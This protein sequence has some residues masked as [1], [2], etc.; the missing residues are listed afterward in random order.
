[1]RLHILSDLHLEFAQFDLPKTDA[2]VVVLAGDVHVGRKGRLWIRNRFDKPVIYVTGNHEYYRHSIPELTDTLRR[3]TE[4]GHIHLLENSAVEI[5]GFSF[6]GCTL[7]SDF[8]L[9][10]DVKTA[11]E[12]AG[13]GMSDYDLIEASGENRLLQPGDTARFHAASVAWLKSELS[14]RDPARTIVVT[15][16]APSPRSIPPF[17]EGS[18]LN[19][20]F[21]SNL[22]ALVESARVPLWIH[23][24]TH[25]N[26][27][28]RLGATRVLSNQRGYPDRVAEGF[29]PGLVVEV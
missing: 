11:M 1:M 29:D 14:R 8:Q 10:G 20:A 17:Y 27:D 22:D 18:I 7:W 16:H 19:G 13:R 21:A 12:E 28:Y 26:V 24:H 9:A 6:L 4:G 2:D 3:E 5:E 15:H 25:Y 23:G